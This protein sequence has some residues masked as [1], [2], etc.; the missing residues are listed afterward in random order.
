[1]WPRFRRQPRLLP[2]GHFDRDDVDGQW[3]ERRSLPRGRAGA[4]RADAHR[5]EPASR[6]GG[7]RRSPRSLLFEIPLYFSRISKNCRYIAKKGNNRAKA[8]SALFGLLILRPLSPTAITLYHMEPRVNA[9]ITPIDRGRP[10]HTSRNS[11]QQHVPSVAFPAR[12][13]PHQLQDAEKSHVGEYCVGG[14]KSEWTGM[15][16]APRPEMMADFPQRREEQADVAFR[17]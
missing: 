2:K 5:R 13:T 9:L 12:A 7:R 11:K 8:A 17:H 16:E 15:Q 6:L 14:R 10:D 4:P 3:E 1:M